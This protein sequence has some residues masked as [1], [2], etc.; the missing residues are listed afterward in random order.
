MGMVNHVI[1]IVIDD[2]RA[3]QFK[4]L[5]N[6]GKLANIKDYLSNGIFSDSTGCYPGITIPAQPTMLTGAYPDAYTPPG[7]HWV[8]RDEQIIRNYN[9][10]DEYTLLNNELGNNINTLFELIPRPTAGLLLGLYRGANYCFPTRKW[11][12]Y[13]LYLWHVII[14]RRNL[15][16]MNTLMMDR[17]LDYFNKP[18]K[19][20]KTSEPPRLA[21][22]WAL[23]TDA[24]LH[25]YGSESN[26]YLQSLRDLDS[27]IGDL[28]NGKGKRKGL[29]ELGYYN[30]TAII[31]TS[32]H[33][34]YEAKKWIDIASY[35]NE[36]GLIPFIPKK[37]EG[38]FDATM[39]SIGFFNLR[40]DSWLEHP[41]IEQMCNYGP[42]KVDLFKALF[43]IPGTKYMYYRE[44]GN[45][46]EKGKIN[47]LKKEND[48]IYSATIEYKN[49]KSK[50]QFAE[51]DIF[52]YSKDDSAAKMLDGKFHTLDE[53]H[54]HTHHVDFPMI[55]DQVARLFRN[56]NF[57]DIMISTL[58]EIMFNFEH[59]F[60][61]N[62]HIY[63]H[64]IGLRSA[65]TLPLIISGPDIPSKELLYSKS[66]D[67]APTIL[68]LLGEPIPPQMV[69]KLLL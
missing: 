42:N 34:N 28:I 17:L 15:I 3:D 58:G 62:N 20:F 68:K 8:I 37:Q 45:T 27:K 32:D 26:L 2:L 43:N 18:K 39:G 21:V 5:L 69:G 24:M 16:H 1:L 9:S 6:E 67:I 61:K 10:L 48:S 22:N 56:P 54:M 4:S 59:G 49:G 41:T 12:I 63:G 30:D 7:G 36:I 64:D 44:D 57:C 25:E 23:A 35:F 29:K 11:T 46:A 33:G 19:F 40:G 52:G 53:W 65:L 66:T 14:R 47:I 60:T 31:I 55:V 38:N 50:Y 51:K 13:R